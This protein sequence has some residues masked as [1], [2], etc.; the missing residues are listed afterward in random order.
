[1]DT[2]IDPFRYELFRNGLA[3]AVLSGA[4][5]GLLGVYV[6]LRG[7]SYIGHGL[8]HSILGWA[9]VSYVIKVNFYLGAAAGGFLSAMMIDRVARRRTLG[10]DAAIG[11]VT[12]ATF[13]VGIFLITKNRGFTRSF[14]A[15][16]FGSILG[17]RIVPDL[18]IIG[19]VLGAAVAVVFFAYRRLM[20]TT[21]DPEVA[22]ASGV[23]TAAVD[24]VFALLL[25]AAIVA[26][27]N[28]IG[29]L[30]VAAALVIPAATARLLTN[31]FSRMMGLSVAIGAASGFVGMEASWY[32]NG[33]SGPT[34][35]LAQVVLFL[36]AFGLSGA[37]GRVPIPAP[38]AAR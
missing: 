6:V 17:V 10:A 36:A 23:N 28:I 1:M 26:T 38:D 3:A 21:F 16:L 24:S 11:V 22:Q 34:I 9:V 15:A 30:L 14:E 29:V 5:C 25:A 12:T 33:P 8:S 18:L 20:F 35:V 27:M 19:G 2:L 4:L 13:A 31:R 37:R 7:M 32:L